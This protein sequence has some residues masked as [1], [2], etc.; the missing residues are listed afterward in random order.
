[1]CRAQGG[2]ECCSMVLARLVLTLLQHAVLTV[3]LAGCACKYCLMH[4]ARIPTTLWLLMAPTPSSTARH[5][6]P[7]YLMITPLP[8]SIY[9]QQLQHWSLEVTLETLI[10]TH[11]RAPRRACSSPSTTRTTGWASCPTQALSRIPY[12][13]CG[14]TST[15][16]GQTPSSHT[17]TGARCKTLQPQC[18]SLTT[19]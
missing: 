12:R 19:T 2:A 3:C 13:G 6:W 14:W 16:Q 10:C 11:T 4:V 17:S 15:C 8:C 9:P 5:T 1:M 18:R 7:C